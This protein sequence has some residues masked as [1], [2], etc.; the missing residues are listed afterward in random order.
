MLD[1]IGDVITRVQDRH[2]ELGENKPDHVMFVIT[3]DGEENSS[4]KFTASGVKPLALAMG[5]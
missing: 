2:D 1:T 5:I 4:R 3:T